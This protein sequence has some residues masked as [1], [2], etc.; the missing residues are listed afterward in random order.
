MPVA[1][2]R[3]RRRIDDVEI[4]HN[5]PGDVRVSHA[6]MELGRPQS[7][8]ANSGTEMGERE[9]QMTSTP[10]QNHDTLANH[11]INATSNDLPP[12]SHVIKACELLFRLFPEFGFLHRPTFSDHIRAGSV[13]SIKIWAILSVTARFIPEIADAHEN[14]ETAG[15]FY[16]EKA[17]SAVML[18]IL[19]RP[20]PDTI[21]TLLLVGLHDW[22]ACK[23]FRA[24]ML[25]GMFKTQCLVIKR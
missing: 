5:G 10:Q 17:R 4:D 12:L 6:S 16:A 13:D 22:G 25:T 1:K 9:F 7:R 24:W 21:Q 8:V 15:E 18:Q 3:K 14:P 23:G 11:H 2:A 20:N 19:D